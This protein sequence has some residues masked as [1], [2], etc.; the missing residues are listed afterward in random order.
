MWTDHVCSHGPPRGSR[1]T[2]PVADP[3]GARGTGPHG[4]CR[5]PHG[6]VVPSSLGISNSM[7]V[8]RGMPVLT[9]YGGAHE[10]S[11]LPK[12]DAGTH[13]GTGYLIEDAD[14]HSR[15]RY[16]HEVL[17][18]RGVPG[19]QLGMLGDRGQVWVLDSI[20]SRT[21]SHDGGDVERCGAQRLDGSAALQD[22]PAVPE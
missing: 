19:T 12:W 16:S 5:H 3:N 13:V 6:T 11:Q 9:R 2:C 22:C 17:V 21:G 14:T 15:C 20:I 7:L 18:P 8:L 10:G 4:E 1:I